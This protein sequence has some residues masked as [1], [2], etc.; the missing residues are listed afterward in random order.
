[1]MEEQGNTTRF[2]AL[3]DRWNQG[4]ES[5]IDE[6]IMHS[7]DRLK[8]FAHGLLDSETRVRRYQETDD[9]LQNTLIRLHRALH[10]VRPETKEAFYGLAATHI[11]WAL[12]DMAR[13]LF[14][15]KGFGAHYR[16]DP[17]LHGADT[18][19]R[20]LHEKVDLSADPIAQLELHERV[21]SLPEDE[22]AV[23]ELIF[24]QGMKQEE[25]AEVL[26]ISER[27]VRR[28]YRCAKQALLKA[29]GAERPE[30]QDET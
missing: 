16:T 15:A 17:G 19:Q 2:Q 22:R 23:F 24:Y 1:M 5:A 18:K 21:D 26:N 4:D 14:G 12:I 9:L 6:I 30:H 8:R 13:S 3:L 29:I 25:A 20:P 10:E 7:Q 28:R 27:T 11:R